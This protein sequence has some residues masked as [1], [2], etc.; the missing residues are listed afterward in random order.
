MLTPSLLSSTVCLI[1]ADLAH[2]LRECAS[3]TGAAMGV[4][5]AVAAV[6]LLLVG[7]GDAS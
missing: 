2:G 1:R 4:C 3:A 7:F 5:V 6:A